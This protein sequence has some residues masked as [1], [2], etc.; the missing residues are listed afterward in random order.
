MHAQL[1]MV[2]FK[3]ISEHQN[4]TDDKRHLHNEEEILNID[5]KIH[6]INS[7]LWATTSTTLTSMPKTC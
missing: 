3:V 1:V 2:L 5:H 4:E 7:L 6:K